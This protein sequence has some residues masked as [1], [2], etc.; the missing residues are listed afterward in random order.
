MEDRRFDS[1]VKTLG[2]GDS[3]RGIMQTLGAGTLAAVFGRLGLQEDAEAKKKGKN[4]KKKKCKGNTRKCNGKCIPQDNCCVD[5]DCED[6]KFCVGG[7]CEKVEFQDCQTDS[8]CRP[9]EICQNGE[10][11][12]Q[13]ECQDAGDCATNELCIGGECRCSF[14]NK[15]CGAACCPENQ[16]CFDGQCVTGEGT[17]NATDDVCSAGGSVTCNGNSGCR[18]GQRP[19]GGVHCVNDFVD[20]AR[21]NCICIDDADCERDF[22]EVGLVCIKGGPGCQCKDTNS[23]RCARLCPTQVGS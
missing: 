11:V 22:N 12:V 14:P 9:G 1:L 8:D 19:D 7:Q 10:C 23:G 2:S 6:Q 5:G 13:Q 20:D 3:R 15:P 17:C 4:K 18:C 21:P 16:V